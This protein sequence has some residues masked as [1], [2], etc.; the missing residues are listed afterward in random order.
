MKVKDVMQKCVVSCGPETNLCAAV[1][2][3]WKNGCGSLPVVGEGG[4]VIGMV[5][6]RDISIA[7]GTRDQMPSQILVQDVMP[8]A[9]FT[10]TKED[11]VH[12]ALKTIRRQKIRRLPVI[13]HKGALH[14]ILC[15]DD[16]VAKAKRYAG[17]EEL[18]F[19]D[20]VETYQAICERPGAERTGK[21]KAA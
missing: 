1:E 2:L 6:D 7:L 13:D 5:T 16:I 4:N 15:M 10:C 11:D 8:Q 14:G 12:C 3:L 17:K 20:V 19:E 9:L 21:A 18:S